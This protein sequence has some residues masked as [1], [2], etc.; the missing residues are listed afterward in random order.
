M[1]STPVVLPLLV[2]LGRAHEEDVEPQRVGAVAL[3]ELVGRDDV[4]LRL[5]HLRAVAVDHPLV[6]QARERLAEADQAEVVQHLREEARVQQVQDRVLDRR[7]CT[8]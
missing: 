4:A 1:P 6:E 3:D 5:R 8:G 2:L 7:R